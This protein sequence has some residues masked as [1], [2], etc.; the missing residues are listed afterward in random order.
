MTTLD[1][2]YGQNKGVKQIDVIVISVI[3][4]KMKSI[5]VVKSLLAG[6]DS[7]KWLIEA[8]NG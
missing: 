3:E 8:E 4:L 6:T 1:I 5:D 2:T 7:N